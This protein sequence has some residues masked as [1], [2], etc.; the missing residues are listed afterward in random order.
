[1]IGNPPYIKQ[2][3]NNAAFDGLKT[4]PYY[5]G[6]MDLWY[7]FACRGL[8][9]LK[10]KT[11]RLAIIATNN[12]TT[13]AGA[14]KLRQKIVADARIEQLIDFGE[15]KV[16]K[17]AGIQTMILLARHDKTP[18]SYHFDLRQI[19]KAKPSYLDVQ[20]LLNP[21]TKA[22][23]G[24]VRLTP[25]FHRA[26]LKGKTLTFSTNSGQTLLDKIAA[27]AN[28]LLNAKTEVAQG[29]V[30]NP[31]VLSKKAYGTY[32]AKEKANL[33]IQP[34]DGV[35]VNPTGHFG[36]KLTK[37]EQHY[38]M[39]L[40]EPQDIDRYAI[41]NQ[42]RLELIYANKKWIDQK[43]LPAKFMNHLEPY[44]R[45]LDVRRETASGQIEWFNLHWPRAARFFEAK[46]RIFASRKCAVPTFAYVETPLAGMMAF[47][48]IQ[49]D[50]VDLKYLTA[51]LN[52]NIMKYWLR[53]KGKMQG[54]MY[55]VDKEPILDMPLMEATP[56]IQAN[57]A[58]LVDAILHAIE[59]MKNAGTDAQRGSIS[60]KMEATDQKIQDI[61][62]E[63]YGLSATEIS[64][65]EAENLK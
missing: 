32:T 34:G 3:K 37:S 61:F 4:S 13:N 53:H 40:I 55:Q 31:D 54:K 33:Q 43:A 60:L 20:A 47:N 36:K 41:V 59:A 48:I 6:K 11:G 18:A 21:Q 9:L 39:P 56:K 49:T 1:M 23:P 5:Q 7:M 38:L 50:R 57:V 22:I 45:V 65:I 8:D 27:K 51:L 44:R 35:F 62:Y 19:A 29:I 15:Y 26:Q 25:E 24:L 64:S 10:T 12:W 17:D 14:K 58:K 42:P 16:F 2:G 63:L 46:P 30:P 52:S 28:F